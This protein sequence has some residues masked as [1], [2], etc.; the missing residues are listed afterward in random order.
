MQKVVI[1][2]KIDKIIR[3]CTNHS[4][5][6]FFEGTKPDNTKVICSIEPKKQLLTEFEF[7]KL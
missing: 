2:G 6:P 4:N 1:P 5:V 7:P 3:N